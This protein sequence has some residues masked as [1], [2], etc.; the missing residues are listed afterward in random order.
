MRLSAIGDKHGTLKNTHVS[1]GQT[2][3]DI[4]EPL[5]ERFINQQGVV[6]LEIGVLNG[7]S[8]NTMPPTGI[9]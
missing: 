9:P 6:I 5:F 8:L 7:A 1:F 3:L 4:Y 2:L